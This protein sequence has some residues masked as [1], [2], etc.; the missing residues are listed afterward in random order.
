M[1][2]IDRTF[3][4][5]K[6]E[7]RKAFIPYIMAGDPSLDDTLTLVKLLEDEGADLVELGVPFPT[8]WQTGLLSRRQ[9]QG[10]LA[11]V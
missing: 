8:R 9:P 3:G 1:N 6:T 11:V 4:K 10:H 5:L 7:K 2:R